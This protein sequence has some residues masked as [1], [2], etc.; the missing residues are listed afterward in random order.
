MNG[1]NRVIFNDLRLLVVEDYDFNLEIVVDML[2]ILGIK[3][4]TAVNGKEA[5]EKV[6]KG[7][8]DLILMDI[9]MPIM[10][11]YEASETIR[12]LPIS[13]PLII[14]LTAS[15][16]TDKEKFEFY[17]MNDFL[18]KPIELEDLEKM[19]MKYFKNKSS[20]SGE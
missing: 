2:N 3:P 8:Y 7:N 15:V 1:E 11:G 10:D 5:V 20:R 13:Q 17:G 12:K 16:L 14:A 19:L 18:I 4:D 9:R 6:E